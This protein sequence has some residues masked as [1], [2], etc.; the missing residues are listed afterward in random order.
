MYDIKAL[1]EEWRQYKKRERRVWYLWGLLL[2]IIIGVV[3]AVLKKNLFYFSDS[4][5]EDRNITIVQREQN[6]KIE[7]PIKEEAIKLIEDVPILDEVVKEKTSES[8]IVENKSVQSHRKMYLN[9]IKT[10]N[11]RAYKDVEERFY[12]SHDPVDSIFLARSYYNQGKYLQAENWALRTNKVNADIEE[13]WII[14]AKSK[15]KQGCKNEAIGVL[16]PYIK[17]TNSSVAKDVLFKIK[18]DTL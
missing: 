15:A 7:I 11:I 2:L 4:A 14:F 12:Q 3:F 16:V 18:N 10:S 8:S 9:I 13:S 6:S 17:R 5:Q 1:E